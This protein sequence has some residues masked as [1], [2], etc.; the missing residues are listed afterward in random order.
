[1]APPKIRNDYDSVDEN[2]AVRI[3]VSAGLHEVGVTFVDHSDAL[4]ERKRQPYEVAFNMHRHPRLSPA[5]Y[6]VSI[7]G[8]FDIQ[9]PGDTAS[10]SFP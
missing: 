5:L 3:P 6:Q 7:N 2:L 8:P 10:R 1:V 9:G 4:L